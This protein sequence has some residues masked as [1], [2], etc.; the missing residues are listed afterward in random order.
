MVHIDYGVGKF[1]GLVKTNV[2]GKVQE[3]IKLV[4]KD[5]DVVFVSIHGIDV[6]KR[7]S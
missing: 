3:A 7:Q 4:Y 6:Y 1:G 2:N 5:N